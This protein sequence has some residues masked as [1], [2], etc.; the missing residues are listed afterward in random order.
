[1]DTLV[2]RYTAPSSR[3]LDEDEQPE[4]MQATPPLSLKFA[5][6]PISQVSHSDLSLVLKLLF[7][8]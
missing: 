1:M 7:R 3:P 4:L 8:C 6:P 2:A 5:L